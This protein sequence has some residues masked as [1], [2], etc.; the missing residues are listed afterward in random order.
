MKVRVALWLILLVG[1]F[2]LCSSRVLGEGTTSVRLSIVAG[3]SSGMEQEVIDRLSDQ[4]S[5]VPNLIIS[6][7][8][9]DWIGTVSLVQSSD[10]VASGVRANGTLTIK[11]KDGQVIHTVSVQTN[12]QDFNLHPGVPSPVNNVLVDKAVH[13]VADLLVDRSSNEIKDAV[14]LE[15]ETRGKLNDAKHLGEQDKYAEALDIINSVT[16]DTPHYQECQQLKGQFEDEQKA[17]NAMSEAESSIKLGRFSR[18]ISQLREVDAT[19]K[20]YRRAQN[21]IADTKQ[22]LLRLQKQHSVGGH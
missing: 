10:T 5:T 11:T 6:T 3:S 21:M 1:I 16:A 19:S 17:Y 12:K 13:E 22:K 8:N 18:A 7:L 4:L 14:A 20:R 15:I 9:P 2:A